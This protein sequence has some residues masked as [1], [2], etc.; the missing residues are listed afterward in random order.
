MKNTV[1]KT[2]KNT[3]KN[4]LAFLLLLATPALLLA[5]NADQSK[6]AHDARSA[7]EALKAMAGTW[8]GTVAAEGEE[9]RETE[10][11]YEVR[12]AGHSVVQTFSPGKPYEMFSVYHLDGEDLLMTHYCAIGNAPKMKFVA[13]GKPG[14]IVWEFNGGSNLDPGKDPHA[15]EG[16]MQIT[17][18]DSYVSKSVGWSNGEPSSKRTFTMK[19]V[20]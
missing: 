7:F 16:R 14:E 18:P 1:K 3:A 13:T 17:G 8:H 2:V 10:I 4:T 5:N 19:R 12:S 9:P 11:V 6:A 15:H 20:D